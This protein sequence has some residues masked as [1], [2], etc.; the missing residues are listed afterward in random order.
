MKNR[1]ELRK[2]EWQDP[3]I[4][5]RRMVSL[6]K[7]WFKEGHKHS[8]EVIEKI[9]L[10][11]KGK[12]ISPNTEFKKGHPKPTQAFSFP[13]KEKHPSWKGDSVGYSGLHKR[14]YKERGKASR[15]EWCNST[16]G[17]YHWANISKE[18][19]INMNDFISLCV[20][21]HGQFDK[22]SHQ[23]NWRNQYVASI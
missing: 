17:K 22:N 21:C 3:I 11:L 7:T 12:R 4:R 16:G 15:C 6:K 8:P 23:K 18:Y 9:R 19:K 5:A 10:K 1:T 2:Q 20:K 14:V 13:E